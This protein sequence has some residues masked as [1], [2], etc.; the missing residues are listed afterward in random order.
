MVE[1]ESVAG[2]CEVERLSGPDADPASV[3][4]WLFELP[5]GA[6]DI[7]DF[8]FV[9]RQLHSSM[10]ADLDAFFFV[11]T[12][13]GSAEYARATAERLVGIVQDADTVTD[14]SLSVLIVR[15]RVPRTFVDCNRVLESTAVNDEP[16]K[17]TPGLAAYIEDPRDIAALTEMHR[18]YLDTVDR[19]YVSVCGAGGFA[20]QL[21]TYAPR[22]VGVERVDAEIVRLLREAYAPERYGT[23][24]LRPEIDL[25]TETTAAERT[26]PDELTAAVAANFRRAGFETAEN[27]TYRLHPS[28]LGYRHSTRYPRRVLCIEVRRDLLA[29]TFTPFQPMRIDPV[30]AARVAAPLAAA[31]REV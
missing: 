12:D 15:C 19:A 1:P 13:I 9:G 8:E 31:A 24:P 3:P 5:H 10:P 28:T 23:W 26:A 25:I 7:A 17:F 27:R 6:T 2:I 14:P 22:E 16:G 20:L 30:K 29:E 4:R 18:Q 11:N 21:H